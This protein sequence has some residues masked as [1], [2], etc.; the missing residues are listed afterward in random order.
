MTANNPRRQL[1]PFTPDGMPLLIGDIVKLI[2]SASPNMLIV[3]APNPRSEKVWVAY[4]KATRSGRI[5][6]TEIEIARENLKLV[7]RGHR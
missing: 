2:H 1:V 6:P 5:V 4:R 7:K 3:D